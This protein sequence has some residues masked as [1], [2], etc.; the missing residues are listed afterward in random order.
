MDVNGITFNAS[1]NPHTGPYGPN[2]GVVPGA[3]GAVEP[4]SRE[5]EQM[6]Y[7]PKGM[8]PEERL[9]QVISKDEI[10]RLLNL[11]QP[12]AQAREEDAV[13]GSRIDVRS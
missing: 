4:P 5:L 3:A 9:N 6:T 7:E 8:T 12:A 1:L 2:S 11:A 10:F 13:P